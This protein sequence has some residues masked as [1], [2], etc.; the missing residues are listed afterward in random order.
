VQKCNLCRRNRE[1]LLFDMEIFWIFGVF[2]AGKVFVV[3]EALILGV[4]SLGK[5]SLRS[6]EFEQLEIEK[7]CW[8]M[9]N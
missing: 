4:V 9:N 5:V 1:D 2:P 6:C 3:V 7:S 8:L